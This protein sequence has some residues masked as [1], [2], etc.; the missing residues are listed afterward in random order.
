MPFIVEPTSPEYIFPIEIFSIILEYMFHDNPLSMRNTALVCHD[1]HMISQNLTFSDITLYTRPSISKSMP[2]R[3]SLAVAVEML[4]QRP[5]LAAVNRRLAV[6]VPQQL[7][8]AIPA[9]DFTSLLESLNATKELELHYVP[10]TDPDHI[11]LTISKNHELCGSLKSLFIRD[12]SMRGFNETFQEMLSSLLVLETLGLDFPLA[13]D[14]RTIQ[15]TVVLPPSVRYLNLC[16]VKPYR[17]DSALAQRHRNGYLTRVLF[18]STIHPQST[19]MAQLPY[20]L[21]ISVLDFAQDQLFVCG[22][23]GIVEV[24]RDCLTFDP[25][26]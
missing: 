21:D 6:R 14:R 3:Q 24:D 13:V 17:M 25:R 8:E 23:M 16:W 15:Q 19:E 5:S 20:Q 9:Q 2:D 26:F 12:R 7:S 11:Y 18:R 10:S 4:A 22:K 1:F